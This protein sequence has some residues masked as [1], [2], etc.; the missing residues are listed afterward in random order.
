[1]TRTPLAC[2]LLLGC[3]GTTAATLATPRSATGDGVD[4]DEAGGE[5]QIH[6]ITRSFG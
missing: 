5:L 2:A 1:M 4:R 6:G 3:G